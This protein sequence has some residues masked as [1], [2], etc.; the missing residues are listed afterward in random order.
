MGGACSTFGGEEECIYVIGGK[1][2]RKETTWKTKT[3]VGGERI[4]WCGFDSYGSGW[5]P[6]QGFSEHGIFVPAWSLPPLVDE[7]SANFCG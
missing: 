6:V 3:Y 4:G 5:E 1:V 7:V 2:R